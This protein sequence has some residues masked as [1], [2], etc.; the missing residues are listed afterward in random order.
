MKTLVKE[1][2]LRGLTDPSPKIRVAVAY[3]IAKI[4]HIDW[5]ETW[6]V[7]FDELM[8]LLK[9]GNQDYVH[10]ATR[11]LAEFIRDDITDQQFPHIAPVLIP[12]LY[13]LFTRTSFSPS[14][15]AR[16]L[17]I[18]R[19]F[20]EILFMIKEEHPE[21]IVNYLEPMLPSWMSAFKSVLGNP[22]VPPE[23]V[24]L[25]HEVLRVSFYQKNSL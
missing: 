23:E 17:V 5:P 14:I 19:D 12:E 11:V 24:S 18:F 16:C 7:L 22:H 10:G 13:Q 1:K 21:A 25:R 4:A 3:V 15:R 8:G 20:A 6:S 2:I 9:S